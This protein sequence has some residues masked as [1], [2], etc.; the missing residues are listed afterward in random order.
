VHDEALEFEPI[1][2]ILF[3]VEPDQV[4]RELQAYYDTGEDAVG[5]QS[6]EYVCGS[7]RGRLYVANPSSQL[8]AGTLKN[9]ID[10]YLGRFGGKV[11]YIHGEQVVGHLCKSPGTIGFLLPVIKKSQ[12]FPTVLL[13]GALPR[14]TFSMGHAHEKRYYLECRAIR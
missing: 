12:L 7:R 9:F 5:G 10:W 14:K 13:D 4:L 8:A 6:F 11:D 1:H 2:R 3:G